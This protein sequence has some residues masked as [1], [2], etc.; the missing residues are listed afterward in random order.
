MNSGG[1][2]GTKSPFSIFN[3]PSPR[4]ERGIQGVRLIK[5]W[6]WVWGERE[7]FKWGV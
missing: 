6:G 4:V 3:S 2:R 7:L 5:I 1:L